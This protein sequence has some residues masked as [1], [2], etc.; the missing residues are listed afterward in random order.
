[1]TIKDNTLPKTFHTITAKRVISHGL[2]GGRT[3]SPTN[4]KYVVYGLKKEKVD[5]ITTRIKKAPYVASNSLS[6]S[7]A[8]DIE[9]RNPYLDRLW[10]NVLP[11]E[12]RPATDAEI[13]EFKAI[14]DECG[15]ELRDVE[16]K[17]MGMG[18][19]WAERQT[20][21][22]YKDMSAMRFVFRGKEFTISNLAD[23]AKEL[24]KGKAFVWF[25]DN[26]YSHMGTDPTNIDK[27]I[28]YV[29]KKFSETEGDIKLGN[30]S[31]VVGAVY[32]FRGDGYFDMDERGVLTLRSGSSKHWSET[33]NS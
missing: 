29:K 22:C 20:R 5:E 32:H 26:G 2:W 11:C 28:G 6:L 33:S 19:L 10:V 4:A 15:V 8:V 21:V 12:I 16:V 9:S 7:N 31:N 24:E 3:I 23:A 17:R 1:M 25:T 27:V 18:G 13:A 14:Y 30:A